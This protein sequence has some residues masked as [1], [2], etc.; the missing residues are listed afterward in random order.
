MENR[1]DTQQRNAKCPYCYKHVNPELI[2]KDCP[3]CHTLLTRDE[4]LY[5]HPPTKRRPL[6]NGDVLQAL[7]LSF[8][9]GCISGALIFG[10]RIFGVF[11][12]GIGWI[13]LSFLVGAIIRWFGVSWHRS[14]VAA[15][16]GLFV[17]NILPQF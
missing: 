3:A 16:I 14:I 4:L 11:V 17:S 9:L 12:F 2:G 1:I 6:L 7:I 10:N 15:T 8:I 13:F 5:D